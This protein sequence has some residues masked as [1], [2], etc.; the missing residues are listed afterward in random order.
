MGLAGVN[1][2]S[3]NSQDL[4]SI[5]E[6]WGLAGVNHM[7]T[8]SQDLSSILKIMVSHRSQSW[9]HAILIEIVVSRKALF[10]TH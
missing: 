8:N 10:W 4:S 9:V 5:L 1:R 7:P 3:T 2:R 6:I